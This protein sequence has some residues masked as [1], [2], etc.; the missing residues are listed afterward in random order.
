MPF[1]KK[2]FSSNSSHDYEVL[3]R[4]TDNSKSVLPQGREIKKG[5]KNAPRSL[6]G[7]LQ[8]GQPR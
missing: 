6:A 8:I 4:K 1:K 2:S 7:A 5:D 3:R